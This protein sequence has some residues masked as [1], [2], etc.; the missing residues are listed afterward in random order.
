MNKLC[1]YSILTIIL[2]KKGSF[3]PTNTVEISKNKYK[4][5]YL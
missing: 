4:R 3:T 2:L 1:L 5:I